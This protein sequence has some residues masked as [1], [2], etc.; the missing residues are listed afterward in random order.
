MLEVFRYISFSGLF[1]PNVSIVFALI[2]PLLDID[3]QFILIFM[4]TRSNE[5][6]LCDLS[7]SLLLPE[8]VYS[9]KFTNIIFKSLMF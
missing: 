3:L 2:E 9:I 7:H 4:S 5:L 8:F 1:Y 6:R